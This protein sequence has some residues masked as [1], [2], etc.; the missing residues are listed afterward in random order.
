[1]MNL[2][3]RVHVRECTTR[4]P[5]RFVLS[6][7][8]AFG[9]VSGCTTVKVAG[10]IMKPTDEVAAETRLCSDSTA[11]L[12]AALS[13]VQSNP[14]RLLASL[15]ALAIRDG[16]IVYANAFGYRTIDS[17]NPSNNQP[18]KI[19]SLYRIASI[20]KLVTTLGALRL[21]EEGKLVLDRDVSDYLGYVL[22]NPNFPNDVITPRMLLTHTSSLRDDGG[23]Y[24]EAK[25]A[26]KD[27]L[28]LG[29]SLYKQG[30]MWSPKAKPGAFFAYAN[31]PWGVLGTVMERAS[32]ERFDRLLQRTVFT[33]LALSGGFNPAAFSKETL[34]NT[35]TLY[36]KR[37]EMDGKEIWNSA[38]PWVAQ[39][40]DYSSAA[41][42]A[43]AD[44]SYVIG[45]N[46]T[47]FGP[48]GAARLSAVDL[49]VIMLMLMN[50]GI[51]NGHEFLSK[52]TI[53][54]MLSV[55]WRTNGKSGAE[56]NGESSYGGAQGAMNAWGLGVQHFLDKTG[57]SS[58][59]RLVDG[60]GFTA[61]G[62]LGDAW[63][64]HSAFVFDRKTKNGMI[65]MHGGS[66]FDPESYAGEYSSLYRHEELVLSALYKFAIKCDSSA[67]NK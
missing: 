6:V 57:K 31:L 19:D 15:S 33:P 66:A 45:S 40:D 11:R 35:A 48:Q 49:G 16:K 21:V 4:W 17:T 56:S 32:G 23:Y 22:R 7:G 55:Q 54:E 14:E 39:V 42:V 34:A 36:R 13:A 28:V 67:Q 52:Q 43:R 12:N 37:T 64:L 38:G 53:D 46:G 18:A 51:H 44:A 20:S 60:G 24:W 58:G 50:D 2:L 1:M 10:S 41:P 3:T 5:L 65:F 59:D 27:A 30:A 25:Y 29:G 26:L 62:H 47:A 63:G 9:A 61:V 8:V